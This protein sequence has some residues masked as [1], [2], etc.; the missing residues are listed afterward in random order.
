M[1]PAS[2]QEAELEAAIVRLLESRD[3]PSEVLVAIADDDSEGRAVAFQ[4]AARHPG[5]IQ[6][7]A[8][9]SLFD[10]VDEPEQEQP[11]GSY[12]VMVPAPH[13]EAALEATLARLAA[14][15]DPP[16][17]VLVVIGTDDDAAREVAEQA[18]A[19][20]PGLVQ[21]VTEAGLF[22]VMAGDAT[23]GRV[24]PATPIVDAVL[25]ARHAVERAATRIPWRAVAVAA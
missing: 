9:D 24:S 22:D 7:V 5:L 18:A 20:H 11:A 23:Y 25:G 13:D 16:S 3:P 1:V 12:S 8:E 10:V 19:R 21:V 4:A 2:R 14:G 17:E 15:D 6:V